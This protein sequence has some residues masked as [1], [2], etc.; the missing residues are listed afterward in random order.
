MLLAT[1]WTYNKT[2]RIPDTTTF[3]KIYTFSSCVAHLAPCQAH[4][5]TLTLPVEFFD[6]LRLQMEPC[7]R[8]YLCHVF[9]IK[10][11]KYARK[12]M[13][14]PIFNAVIVW[15]TCL[16]LAQFPGWKDQ[17]QPNPQSH[18]FKISGVVQCNMSFIIKN[19]ICLSPPS[20]SIERNKVIR[21]TGQKSPDMVRLS[22]NSNLL[23]LNTSKAFF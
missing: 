20:Q 1:F 8:R 3:C 14:I 22:G 12:W 11:M 17:T 21:P 10:W 18:G 15:R 16:L 23:P 13:Q 5:R 7:L 9:L 4:P 6:R 19:C 2:I